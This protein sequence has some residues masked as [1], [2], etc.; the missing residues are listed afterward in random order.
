MMWVLGVE[1]A[2]ETGDHTKPTGTLGWGCTEASPLDGGYRPD[3]LLAALT[4]ELGKRPELIA[5]LRELKTH[6]PPERKIGF[7][8]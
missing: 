4:G 8:R 7:H 6:R 2:R 3:E 1:M 5:G